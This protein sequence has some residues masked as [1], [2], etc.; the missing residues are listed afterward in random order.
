LGWVR[1]QE[2]NPG[3]HKQ[4]TVVFHIFAQRIS[5]IRLSLNWVKCCY[6]LSIEPSFVLVTSGILNQ[7]FKFLAFITVADPCNCAC[8]AVLHVTLGGLYDWFALILSKKISR[9]PPSSL[10]SSSV[11]CF[12]TA[13]NDTNVQFLDQDDDDDPDTELYMTQ[14]FACGTAFAVSVLDSLM[15]TVYYADYFQFRFFVM[16]AVST[17]RCRLMSF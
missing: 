1:W 5:L 15:S 3:K 10:H 13:G 8:T 4:S 16:S 12:L 11:L 2:T 9:H 6:T 14:P 7:V 17:H